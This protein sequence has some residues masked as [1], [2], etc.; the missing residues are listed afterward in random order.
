M[1]RWNIIM[2][3]FPSSLPTQT[4]VGQR[5]SGYSRDELIFDYDDL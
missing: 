1:P 3:R 5:L 2:P 4:L